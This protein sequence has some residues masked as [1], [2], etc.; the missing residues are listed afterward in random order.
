MGQKPCTSKTNTK[1]EAEAAKKLEP[2]LYYYSYLETH[3]RCVCSFQIRSVQPRIFTTPIVHG[4]IKYFWSRDVIQARK[5]SHN[6]FLN[7][8]DKQQNARPAVWICKFVRII[9]SQACYR[10]ENHIW[11]EE[12]KSFCFPENSSSWESG[13]RF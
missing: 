12:E 10:W 2:K 8:L 5:W 9:I 13:T 6:C 1:E 7:S 11:T 3:V 4:A